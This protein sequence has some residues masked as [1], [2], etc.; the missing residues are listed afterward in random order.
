[1][2]SCKAWTVY[3]VLGFI[4]D[5]EKPHTFDMIKTIIFDIMNIHEED[6][7]IDEPSIT[8]N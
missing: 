5:S 3:F 6:C 8:F 4:S 1:M 7:I 2:A